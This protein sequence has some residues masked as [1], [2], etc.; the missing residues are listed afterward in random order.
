MS[1]ATSDSTS[2][3]WIS[4][5]SSRDALP[6]STTSSPG[7]SVIRVAGVIQLSGLK[8]PASE[9]TSTEPSCFRITSR[10]AVGSTADTRP[11]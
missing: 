5:R 1:W 9:W 6:F 11:E 10:T 3:M 8:P 4:S 7:D 2:S